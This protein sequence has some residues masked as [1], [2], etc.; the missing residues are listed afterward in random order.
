MIE[1]ISSELLPCPFCGGIP[2]YC[3][4]R[5]LGLYY[6]QCHTCGC[7]TSVQYN[8]NHGRVPSKENAKRK[9]NTRLSQLQQ[10]S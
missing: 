1:N 2:E 5:S 9:W 4:E 6:V 10:N 7:R 8:T 3:Q